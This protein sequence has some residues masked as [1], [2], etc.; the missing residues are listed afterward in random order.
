MDRKA[1]FGAVILSLSLA[2]PLGAFGATAELLSSPFTYDF[3]VPGVLEESRT[4]NDSTSPYFWLSGGAKL[5]IEDGVG[6]TVKGPLTGDLW[7]GI[8]S[9][10]DPIDTDGGLYPENVF[11]MITKSEWNNFTQEISFRI[12]KT[13]L[14]SSYNRDAYSGLF[15]LSRYKDEKNYYYAGLRMDGQAVIKKKV[16]GIFYTLGT[17][18]VF[19]ESKDYNKNTNANLLPLDQVMRLKLVTKDLDTSTEL[20]LSVDSGT[21]KYVDILDVVDKT[22]I[23]G[24]TYAGIESDFMDVVFDDYILTR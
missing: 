6:K 14:T 10:K 19:G 17:V 9:K 18:P 16:N 1:I 20:T 7:K 3:S 23:K 8:Y 24:L 5:V 11:A 12:D 15:L 2:L 21:G 4:M 22:S 13:N